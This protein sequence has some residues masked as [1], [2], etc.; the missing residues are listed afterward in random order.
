[1]LAAGIR[2][3]GDEVGHG[4]HVTSIAAGNGG[5]PPRATPYVGVAPEAQ[6][7]FARVTTDSTNSIDNAS[8]VLG[9]Q[10]LFDRADFMQQPIAV[11]LSLGSDFG[12]HDG[13]MSWEQVL[14]S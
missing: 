10:F 3:P 11:N 12:P 14:A 4:T 1:L 9:V 8:L 7:V 5:L 2:L 13:T 6:I